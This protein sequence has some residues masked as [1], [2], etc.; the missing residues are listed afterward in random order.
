MVESLTPDYQGSIR[1]RIQQAAPLIFNFD[2]PL[3][4][5]ISRLAL[6]TKILAHY[7]TREIGFETYGLWQFWLENRL[8]EIMPYYNQL[9]DTVNKDFDYLKNVDMW[10]DLNE[11]SNKNEN[12]TYGEQETT[13]FTGEETIDT[14]NDLTSKQVSDK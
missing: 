12:V 1:S 13:K 11:T 3:A 2:F 14:T 6:E 4:T 7:Y 5:G 10:E 8:N 9:Y